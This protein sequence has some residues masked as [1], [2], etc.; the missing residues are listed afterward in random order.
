MRHGR[1]WMIALVLAGTLAMCTVHA[2][3]AAPASPEV[4]SAAVD[5]TKTPQE[6]SAQK[7][8]VALAEE[9]PKP[10]V[11][12]KIAKPKPEP[13]S[14]PEVKKP[15]KTKQELKAEAKARSDAKKQA[16]KEAAAK[17]KAEAE[18]KSKPK[19]TAKEKATIRFQFDAVPY[20]DVLKRF[21]QMIGKPI[22]GDVAI[23]GSLTFSD[24]LPYTTDEAMD[25]LNFILAMKGYALRE[26][27]R[28][29]RL[30]PLAEVATTTKIFHG[31][32][33]VT[34]I[35]SNEIVTVVL[36]VKYIDSTSAAKAVI[37]L[38]SA[39]GSI[40]PLDNKRGM[41]ITDTLANIQRVEELL[42]QLD[43][44]MEK[45]DKPQIKS[46]LLH[47]ASAKTVAAILAKMLTG[48][49]ASKKMVYDPS[50]RRMVPAPAT[51]SSAKPKTATSKLT[52]A[53]DDRINIII[54]LGPAEQIT[55][56]EQIIATL[57]KDHREGEDDVRVF[58]LKNASA[59]AVGEAIRR[60][61]PSPRRDLP[62]EVGVT[63]DVA[64]NRV[65]VTAA[66][67]KMTRIENLISKLDS[68]DAAPSG[69]PAEPEEKAE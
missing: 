39:F 19:V 58:E 13:V 47:N 20:V 5:A 61:F 50:T 38:I 59:T 57:D 35:R 51:P 15:K 14:K 56:A 29:L 64:N 54:L 37:R 52:V 44:E 27:G 62:P 31:L 42:K 53:Y 6:S 10:S 4:P 41:V 12:K 60:M 45:E 66:K 36:G 43:V 1:H 28:F 8:P 25:T 7:T 26:E 23:E 48:I 65:I 18:V 33:A 67:L 21:S 69:A 46:I 55:Q 16:K 30:R 11:E 9:A 3:E 40:T 49:T 63:A 24:P 68:P 34:G 32:G 2:Q 22:L 17:A